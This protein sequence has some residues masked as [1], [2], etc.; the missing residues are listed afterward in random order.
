MNNVLPT[1]KRSPELLTKS[2]SSSAFS[3][4]IASP[5]MPSSGLPAFLLLTLQM[6]LGFSENT[7]FHYVETH[8]SLCS[9]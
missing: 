9:S 6:F 5:S 7:F 3:Y 2:L 4:A 1:G 8:Y